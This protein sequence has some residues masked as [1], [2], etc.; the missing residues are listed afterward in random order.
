MRTHKSV[1]QS[2]AA[3][4]LLL[5]ALPLSAQVLHTNQRWDQCA[6]VIDPGLTQASWHQFVR[7]AGLA[8][9]FRPIASAEPLGRGS[10]EIALV[11]WGTRID[12]ADD[13]WNDTFSH[14]DSTH[15]LFEGDAL[16]IPGMMVRAGV[17][18]RIDVGGY[19]TRALGSN[20]GFFGGQVQYN[21]LH[22]VERSFAA[23][24]RLGFVRMYGPEDLSVSTYGLDF[25]VSKEISRFSPYAT[26]SGYLSKGRETTS[27]VSLD[28]ESVLGLQGTAGVAVRLWALRL[29]VELNVA[30][31]PGYAFKLAFA[32]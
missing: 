3:L 13:A 31:V 15:W 10:F 18:D 6:F 12:P 7:E 20:Y 1:A 23:S 8:T 28:D 24:A 32:S 4:L 22:D 25:V 16:L 21:V 17:T 11:D 30:R 5:L 14:P 27:K 29:G 26:V 2:A 19:V 9:Y